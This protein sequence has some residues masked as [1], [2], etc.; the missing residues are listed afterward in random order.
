[1]EL[2]EILPEQWKVAIPLARSTLD[3]INLPVDHIPGRERIFKALEL[4]ISEIKVCIIGQ[5]PYPN[6]D[7]AM[8]LAFSAQN[9][10]AKLPPTLRNIFKELESDVGVK[11]ISGDLTKWQDEGVLLLNRVLTTSPSVS[12]GHKHLGWQ[13]FTDQ[14]VQYLAEKPIIFLL[15]GRSAQELAPL[16]LEDNLILGVHPSPLSAYRGFFGS[17]PFSE[18]DKRLERLGLSPID[19]KI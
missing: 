9:R 18:I 12:Q 14:V 3:V 2:F 15:W 7:D 13:R 6:P 5:D 17:R 11:N 4:P 8:G 1:L 10:K 16:I 19:W